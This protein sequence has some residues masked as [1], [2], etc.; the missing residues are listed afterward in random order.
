LISSTD[1]S[2]VVPGFL[3]KADSAYAPSIGD[4]AA[5]IYDGVVYPTI[6]G[7]A[8]PSAKVGEASL[9][10]CKQINPKASANS[11]SVSNIK[12]A[13]L[14]FP[15]TAEKFGPPDLV[16]WREKVKGYLDEMGGAAP[17][18]FVWEDTVPPWPTPTPTPTPTPEPTPTPD[19]AVLAT[20]DPSA[21]PAAS[22]FP[23]P[24]TSATPSPSASPGP[25]VITPATP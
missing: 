6:V 1:P 18:L 2:I 11:R 4:Y 15:G 5:V 24:E 7:D 17:E 14:I 16:K 22:P 21:T 20:P 25:A 19:P 9:R 23:S 3:L 12:V 8:G 10:L 13:Y